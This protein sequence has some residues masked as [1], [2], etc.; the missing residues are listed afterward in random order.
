MNG[1]CD[2][3]GGYNTSPILNL[4]LPCCTITDITYEE[5][6]RKTSYAPK[7]KN[8]VFFG[9]CKQCTSPMLCKNIFQQNEL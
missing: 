8:P 7:Q 4:G 2:K 5:F 9:F 3:A 6:R 1:M